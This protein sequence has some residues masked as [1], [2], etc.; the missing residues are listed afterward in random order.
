MATLEATRRRYK[1]DGDLEPYRLWDLKAKNVYLTGSA[2]QLGHVWSAYLRAAG[3]LV[4]ELDLNASR[5]V[6]VTSRESLVAAFEFYQDMVKPVLGGGKFLEPRT[7]A[8]L[9][10]AAAIDAVPGTDGHA[11]WTT[12]WDDILSVNL[13]GVKNA[14]DV[15]GGAMAE[16][17]SGSIVL[18]S[19]MYGLVSPDQRRYEDG[20]VKPAAYGATKAALINLTKYLAT[21]WGPRGV[22]VNAICYGS[23]DRADYPDKFRQSMEAAIPLGRMAQ[24]DEWCGPLQFLLSDA[25]SY[26][27]GSVL[28][29]D[30][31]YTVW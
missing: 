7:P 20:F 27:T 28:T 26:M 17:G 23:L 15:I 6:D 18:V 2:G 5:P 21:L 11:D 3:A 29:V 13:T 14:C 10:C 16:A 8:G 25:S 31:G 22:R 30:G 12:G 9:V 4:F 19:S 1:D 24:A